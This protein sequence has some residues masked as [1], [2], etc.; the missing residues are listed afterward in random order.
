MSTVTTLDVHGM[1][2]KGCVKKIETAM[3]GLGVAET[4]VDLAEKKVT[5]TYDE[6]A[7]AIDQIKEAIV[8]KGFKVL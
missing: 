6:G 2:C 3:G 4:Q 8:G 5:V 1:G 7:V